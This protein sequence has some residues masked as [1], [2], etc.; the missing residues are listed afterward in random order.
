MK[1]V[2]ILAVAAAILATAIGLAVYFAAFDNRG[3]P[4]G[5]ISPTDEADGDTFFFHRTR[6][7]ALP[8]GKDSIKV[9]VRLLGVDA[10]DW[11]QGDEDPCFLCEW[12]DLAAAN[13]RT[14]QGDEEFRLE[15]YGED[16]LG[17]PLVIAYAVQENVGSLNERLV[18]EGYARIYKMD[19]KTLVPVGFEKRLLAAQVDAALSRAGMWRASKYGDGIHIVAIRYWGEDERVVLANFGAAPTSLSTLVI[20]DDA[21]E[22][23]STIMAGNKVLEPAQTESIPCPIRTWRDTGAKAYLIDLTATEA[24]SS[25]PVPDYCY[26]GF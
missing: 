2:G 16:S 13:L 17:R 21:P 15:L 11:C 9:K 6:G 19:S 4:V 5:T 23:P 14:R 24:S 22:R 18:R 10:P 26:R 25:E 12:R 8:G 20:R 7:A 1:K 3:F